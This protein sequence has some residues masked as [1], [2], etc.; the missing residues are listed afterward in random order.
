MNSI[1]YRFC[2]QSRSWK[3]WFHE[4]TSNKRK[5]KNHTIKKWFEV[6][7]QMFWTDILLLTW[8]LRN[9]SLRYCCHFIWW[10]QV[11]VWQSSAGFREPGREWQVC[12]TLMAFP[13]WLP[14]SV[15]GL[16]V[17]RFLL[18]WREVLLNLWG[19][20]SSLALSG[21]FQSPIWILF[22]SMLNVILLKPCEWQYS[23]SA[24]AE[25]GVQ[26]ELLTLSIS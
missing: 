2:C 26:L 4:N 1:I 14:H 22:Y 24:L 8:T 3:N 16:N 18:D 15:R 21:I 25:E 20:S 12:C 19:K 6:V 5:Y 9:R 17:H 13:A 11:Q 10:F 7:F 23:W